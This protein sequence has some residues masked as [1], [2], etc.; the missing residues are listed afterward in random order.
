MAG[1]R[2]PP[3]MAIAMLIAGTLAGPPAAAEPVLLGETPVELQL[4]LETP[5]SGE[6]RPDVALAPPPW[7]P[8]L[9]V[10]ANPWLAARPATEP[11]IPAGLRLAR[12]PVGS[13]WHLQYRVARG[14]TLGRIAARFHLPADDL[15]AA[16]GIL[17]ASRRLV[18]GQW[19]R[20]PSPL[21]DLD[22]ERYARLPETIRSATHRLLLIAHFE[23]W[24][25][26]YG[27]PVD[28]LQAVA[29]VESRWQANAL[30]DKGAMGIGQLTPETVDFVCRVL[31]RRACDPWQPEENIRMSAR[32]LRYLLEQTD[33]LEDALA[34][35]YQG[36]GALRAHGRYAV[37][38]PYVAAVL[39]ARTLFAPALLDEAL[40]PSP[41]RISSDQAPAA[42]PAST[43]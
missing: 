14:D 24:A 42:R 19:L 18:A 13:R 1:N 32:F 26:A 8:A 7:L 33:S 16:N 37:A 3:S 36:L 28:L 10:P 4:A 39:N 25:A 20:I 43:S 11:G 31:L 17:S 40:A 22:P 30:S 38:E 23:R 34:A 27:L 15:A 29:W 5:A 9:V 21:D 2:L 6:C 35:Y 41:D 12:S